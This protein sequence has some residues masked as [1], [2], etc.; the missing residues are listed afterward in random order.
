M[1]NRD[2]LDRN[3]RNVVFAFQELY[4]PLLGQL[5]TRVGLLR[6]GLTNLFG[7]LFI[8]LGEVAYQR[9]VL[10][11]QPPKGIADFFGSFFFK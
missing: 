4:H 3:I 11:F 6:G 8:V 9:L 5:I 7:I 2:F 1:G 10:F